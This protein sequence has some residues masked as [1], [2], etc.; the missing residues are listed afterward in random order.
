M[1]STHS[2]SIAF[3]GTYL[4]LASL[5]LSFHPRLVSLLPS[6]H[7]HW[8]EQQAVAAFVRLALAAFWI[9]A[10]ASVCWSRVK[11]GHHTPE[12]VIVGASLGAAIAVVWLTVWQGTANMPL[13]G[14]L[15]VTTTLSTKAA[16]GLRVNADLWEQAAQDAIFALLEAYEKRSAAP[17]RTLLSFPLSP[18]E[19]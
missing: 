15:S 12:Q 1:P 17:L 19:L 2:C 3:F 13:L 10:A 11:L 8:I 18:R 9:T 4:T 7:Q 6:A 16:N 14:R 5:F